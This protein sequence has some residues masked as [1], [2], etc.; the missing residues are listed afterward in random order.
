[1]LGALEEWRTGAEPPPCCLLV[2]N[3]CNRSLVRHLG[4]RG[5]WVN[6]TTERS[7]NADRMYFAPQKPA[8]A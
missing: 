1:M 7:W 3:V 8:L 4:V 5:G 6:P 2:Q